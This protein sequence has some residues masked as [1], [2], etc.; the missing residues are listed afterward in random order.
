[1][2]IKKVFLT[3]VLC[4]SGNLLAYTGLGDGSSANPYQIANV[5]DFQQLCNTPDDWWASFILTANIDLTGETLTPIGN[6]STKFTGVF[7]GKDKIISNAVINQ[8]SSDYI[9]LFG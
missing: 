2:S 1:M 3:A 4:F 8:P 6:E 9:G 5:A 7:H